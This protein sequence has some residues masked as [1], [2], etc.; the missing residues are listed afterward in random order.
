MSDE[1][2]HMIER[3]DR[4]ED[5]KVNSA[6]AFAIVGRRLQMSN[7]E[8]S[9]VRVAMGEIKRIADAIMRR[10]PKYLRPGLEDTD[11]NGAWGGVRY[12]AES[13]L[14]AADA[15]NI[16]GQSSGPWD[17]LRGK[18]SA[19]DFQRLSYQVGCVA[20]RNRAEGRDEV[21]PEDRVYD[22][23]C[24][25]RENKGQEGGHI[26]ASQPASEAP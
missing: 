19:E 14:P 4:G 16:D 15:G 17:W 18:L 5:F 23:P 2:D 20:I 13:A 1:I 22:K 21:K 26:H 10:D 3:I 12:Y 25:C 24:Y 6:L 9:K 7:G 11:M 8:L